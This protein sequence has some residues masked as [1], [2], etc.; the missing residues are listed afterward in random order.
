MLRLARPLAA[1]A[2]YNPESFFIA[3]TFRY[4]GSSFNEGC[5]PIGSRLPLPPPPD[6]WRSAT[7][8]ESDYLPWRGR[9]PAES[10]N[11]LNG[12]GVLVA[13]ES[14]AVMTRY[15]ADP[16]PQALELGLQ[17]YSLH[18]PVPVVGSSSDSSS[19][20]TA[21]SST[22][23]GVRVVLPWPEGWN[24]CIGRDGSSTS[25][26]TCAVGAGSAAQVDTWIPDT[27]APPPTRADRK[28]EKRR[29]KCKRGIVVLGLQDDKELAEG[30]ARYFSIYGEVR[31]V[32][33]KEDKRRGGALALVQFGGGEQAQ[34]VLIDAIIADANKEASASEFQGR[35]F[36]W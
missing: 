23:T 10:A 5:W 9:Q 35:L 36:R 4:R 19:T 15:I 6:P 22:E 12:D 33:V 3:E 29:R 30:I 17:A 16:L 2:D 31:N 32:V 11:T 26:P 34:A 20:A 27:P 1:T 21:T 25:S 7:G 8:E 14:A 18:L 24:R 13:A 28:K